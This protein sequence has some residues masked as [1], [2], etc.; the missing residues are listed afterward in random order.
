[1]AVKVIRVI[2]E[3]QRDLTKIV[4]QKKA[5]YFASLIGFIVSIIKVLQTYYIFSFLFPI[6]YTPL[7]L[8]TYSFIIFFS[9]LIFSLIPFPTPGGLG[10]V[11]GV[12]VGFF[13]LF[14]MK[15]HKG[16]LYSAIIRIGQFV[17]IS[18]GLINLAVKMFL[19][20][21]DKKEEVL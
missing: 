2:K 20:K 11:E 1:M 10:P 13:I 14:G 12:F 9:S 19:K 3:F 6:E 4:K 5:F 17:S 21:S 18:I 16:L 15:E 8:L 7:M